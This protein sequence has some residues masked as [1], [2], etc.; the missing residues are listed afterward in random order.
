[1]SRS[2]W[3]CFWTGAGS[4]GGMPLVER[5]QHELWLTAAQSL[6][7]VVLIAEFAMH[8]WEA[9][10][11]LVPF[12]AQLVLPPT[13]GGLDVRMAFTFGYLAAAVLLLVDRGRRAAIRH[14]PAALRDVL[15]AGA[16]G[17]AAASH[18]PEEL[19]P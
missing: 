12:V 6:F 16:Q 4:L 9:V 19:V 2:L 14:W 8:R 11:L 3:C 18:S 1:M 13:L 10:A 5:Q 17:P 7:A 15:R